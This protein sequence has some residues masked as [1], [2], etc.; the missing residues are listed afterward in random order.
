MAWWDI[1]SLVWERASS[2]RTVLSGKRP[3]WGTDWCYLMCCCFAGLSVLFVCSCDFDICVISNVCDAVPVIILCVRCVILNT[4]PV[5]LTLYRDWMLCV[6]VGG[7][8]RQV[9]RSRPTFP[10]C[11][12]FLYRRTRLRRWCLLCMFC[13]VSEHSLVMASCTLKMFF[14]ESFVGSSF[15]LG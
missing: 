13:Y 10:S 6:R 12:F 7:V 9:S 5:K 1:R 2:V 11:R 3:V 8:V 14:S 4:A 15:I